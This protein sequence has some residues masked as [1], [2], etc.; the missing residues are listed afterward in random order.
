MLINHLGYNNS[1]FSKAIGL[2]NN[3]TIGRIINENRK[4]SFEVLSSIALT[5]GNI[6]TKWLLTGEGEMVQNIEMSYESELDKPT[7]RLTSKMETEK[8]FEVILEVLKL[9]KDAPRPDYVS[10]LAD[11]TYSVKEIGLSVRSIDQRLGNVENRLESLERKVDRLDF[12]VA[13]LEERVNMLDGQKK[14]GI[15][16]AG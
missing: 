2:D 14:D 1:S 3:V 13:D 6:N 5:F 12:R 15:Q 4:P 8:M 10:M 16:Q 11:L 7:K 9:Q